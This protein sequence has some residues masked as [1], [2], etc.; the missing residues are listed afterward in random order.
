MVER[1]TL[2]VQS[3]KKRKHKTSKA[4]AAQEVEST[5]RPELPSDSDK[6]DEVAYI[7]VEAK[8]RY[9]SSEWLLDSCASSHM[10][11]QLSLF[12]GPL[13]ELPNKKW[14]KVGGSYLKATHI[15]KA[16][17]GRKKGQQVVL[18]GVLF[19]LGLRVNLVS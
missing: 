11:N 7:T 4:Y 1:L 19:V 3:L 6:T 14:I 5:S 9:P 10:T 15:G 12:R 16:V 17:I 2:K 13:M 18:K 8:G